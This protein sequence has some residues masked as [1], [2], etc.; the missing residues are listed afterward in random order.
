M[1]TR[2]VTRVCARMANYHDA[3]RMTSLP[4]VFDSPVFQATRSVTVRQTATGPFRFTI[5]DVMEAFTEAQRAVIRTADP[6]QLYVLGHVMK[7]ALGDHWRLPA[8]DTLGDAAAGVGIYTIARAD[9]M[10]HVRHQIQETNVYDV[11]LEE[12]KRIADAV[13]DEPKVERVEALHAQLRILEEA[14]DRLERDLERL[15]RGYRRYR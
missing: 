1:T 9:L 7:R 13:M 2:K 6:C 10:A 11:W 14:R 12:L 4:V 15:T 3:H 8:T 5:E